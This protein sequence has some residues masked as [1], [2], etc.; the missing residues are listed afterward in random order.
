MLK[1]IIFFALLCPAFSAVRNCL[2]PWQTEMKNG[3]KNVPCTA[4]NAAPC[5]KGRNPI[6]VFTYLT[7]NYICCEDIFNI[8]TPTC[9][10]YYDTLKLS[11]DPKS[12]NACPS[13]Y[14]CMMGKNTNYTICCGYNPNINYPEP[15]SSFADLEIT[16]KYLPIAPTT[17][18]KVQGSTATAVYTLGQEVQ[19]ADLTAAPTVSYTPKDNTTYYT[20]IAFDI[21][22]A[23]PA[24]GVWVVV[25][26][27]AN[28][29]NRTWV[30]FATS[31]A[32][33]IQ[34]WVSQAAATPTGEHILVFAVFEQKAA[35]QTG[36]T[37][38]LPVAAD[39]K[40]TAWDVAAFLT[41]FNTGIGN[42]LAGTY[43]KVI[44][45]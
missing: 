37:P 41:K 5:A 27:R 25:N 20:L 36:A 30:D 42:I 17:V 15:S 32:S 19:A 33:V 23:A 28:A 40:A 22:V 9:P 31:P 3:V 29:A 45:P 34:A 8:T 4:T 7:F 2:N 11:C 18:L 13:G 1:L 26:A 10:K 14:T 35:F 43:L 16:P 39:V 38:A 21:S 44:A 24:A 6:C 12:T